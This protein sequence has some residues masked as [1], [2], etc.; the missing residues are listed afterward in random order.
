MSVIGLDIGTTR[1]KAL[2]HQLDRD[3]P[4]V[5]AA[6]TPITPSRHGDLR[7][8]EAV[9]QV[10]RSCV[11]QLM[12]R[13]P[14]ALRAEVEGIGIA[15]LSEEMVL[16]DEYGRSVAPTPTWY[17]TVVRDASAR[18]GLNPSFSWS[19][20]RW[21]RE[22]LDSHAQAAVRMVT[23][24][25]SY[26][27]ARI[28]GDSV[29]AVEYSHASRTG[30]FDV[31]A[32]QWDAAAFESTGWPATMLPPLVASGTALGSVSAEL[33]QG[34]GMPERARVAVSG[35]DHFCAAFAAGLR[36]PGQV[37]LSSG[38]SEAHVVLVNDISGLELP[39]HVQFGRFIDGRAFYLHAHMPSGHLHAHLEQLVGGR[40][41]LAEFERQALSEPVGSGGL[42][43]TPGL[44]A[45]PGYSVR[46]LSAHASGAAF[47]RAA[48]EGL[49][50]A[51]RHLDEN[52]V[53]LS[54][55][56][57]KEVVA[58]GAATGNPLWSRIRGA[59]SIAPLE[60]AQ[61]TELTAVGAAHVF[62]RFVLGQDP[63]P[64]RRRRVAVHPGEVRAYERLREGRRADHADFDEDHGGES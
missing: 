24:L 13:I 60:V 63:D 33:R 10:A 64:V 16:I 46:G 54:G 19:K 55:V 29:P 23:S 36:G 15:S 28:A 6:P 4:L 51:A 58:T 53:D 52:L 12:A 41:R 39:E 2:L 32:S 3:D 11:S 5:V 25:G 7:D 37:F 14:D 30:F 57:A 1:I 35:H 47:I 43:F 61:E 17:A 34:W 56:P 20:L 40:Q 27:A 38:T 9:V 48:Q 21:A 31:E 49:A 42:E 50:L 26:V 44:G 8:A 45:D 59:V 22:S 62:R 18:A